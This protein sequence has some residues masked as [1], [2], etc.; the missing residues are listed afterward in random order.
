MITRED[1]DNLELWAA[2]YDAPNS[3]KV[4]HVQIVAEL[5]EYIRYLEAEIL[6]ERLKGMEL[7]ESNLFLDHQVKTL[8]NGE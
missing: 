8:A 2:S 5:I 1:I 6:S 4:F 7:E 3:V